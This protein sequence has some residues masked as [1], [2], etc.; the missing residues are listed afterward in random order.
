LRD[1]SDGPGIAAGSQTETGAMLSL[2]ITEAQ[3]RIVMNQGE[4]AEDRV[5]IVLAV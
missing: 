2:T 4:S 3:R 1:P 5:R